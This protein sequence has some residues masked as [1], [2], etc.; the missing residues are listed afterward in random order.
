[1]AMQLESQK[2]QQ[3]A[4]EMFRTE[5]LR[6]QTEQLNLNKE[7]AD[8]LASRLKQYGDAIR[9]SLSKQP[10]SSALDFLPFINNFTRVAT[11]LKAP[12]ELYVQLLTP[13]LST[14]C[15]TLLHKMSLPDTNDFDKVKAHLTAELRLTS[16]YFIDEFNKA[17]RY[18]NE[19]YKAYTT[20]L[21]MLLRYFTESKEVHN[22]DALLQLIVCDRVKATLSST[23]LA[24]V[25][26]FEALLSHKWAKVDELSNPLDEYVSNFDDNDQVKHSMLGATAK[27]AAHP[28][29]SS[30]NSWKRN[31]QQPAVVETEEKRIDSKSGDSIPPFSRMSTVQNAC[32]SK[33]N[34][35]NGK[36][37][38]AN[39]R[40]V[41]C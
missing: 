12:K 39:I 38:N 40:T 35:K 14:K 28:R 15:R 17:S 20:R 18:A 32:N 4:D 22:Y 7:R 19:T 27:P 16:S 30:F 13:Y 9:N 10:E 21:A 25:L 23:A 6:L 41:I 31:G 1:M 24:H 2:L 3:T 26:R 8:S 37:D 34:G 36:S 33:Q 29:Y 11:A 5:Q